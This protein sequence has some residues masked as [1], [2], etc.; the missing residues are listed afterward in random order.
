[1][2]LLLPSLVRRPIEGTDSAGDVWIGANDANSGLFERLSAAP[3][4]LDD[5]AT[6]VA[7][8]EAFFPSLPL[9]WEPS[10]WELSQW[11]QLAK[12]VS[13]DS[14]ALS[15]PCLAPIPLP[16]LGAPRSLWTFPTAVTVCLPVTLLC[17]A[18]TCHL[19]SPVRGNFTALQKMASWERW[20]WFSLVVVRLQCNGAIQ[21]CRCWAD[22]CKEQWHLLSSATSTLN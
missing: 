14:C 19:P 7:A 5:I 8:S 21:C 2:L 20:E 18:C 12:R 16:P 3:R 6:A 17:L 4:T 13:V 15:E 11:R 22:G 9:S 10:S 1:M